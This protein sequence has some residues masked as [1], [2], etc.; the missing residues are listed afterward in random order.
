MFV[1]Q[2]TELF[3][4]LQ[5]GPATTIDR[6]QVRPVWE[7]RR[8]SQ[9][10]RILHGV[11]LSIPLLESLPAQAGMNVEFFLFPSSNEIGLRASQGLKISRSPMR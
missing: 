1:A 5:V 4:K 2:K 6:V 10:R 3:S 11:S 7:I 9:W 8:D